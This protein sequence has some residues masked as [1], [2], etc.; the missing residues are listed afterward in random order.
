MASARH[1]PASTPR[2]VSYKWRHWSCLTGSVRGAAAR[3]RP[4]LGR[5][6][7]R[8]AAVPGGGWPCPP[9]TP[10]HAAAPCASPQVLSNMRDKIRRHSQEEAVLGLDKLKPKV[11]ERGSR[12]GRGR[13]S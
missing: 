12:G 8:L 13:P 5:Q 2:S 6:A 10:P 11:P 3:Q 9:Q 4:A 1:A 7:A